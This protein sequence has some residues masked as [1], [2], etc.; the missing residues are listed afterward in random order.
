MV[1]D[2]FSVILDQF[3]VILGQFSVILG[4]FSVILESVLSLRTAIVLMETKNCEAVPCTVRQKVA[5]R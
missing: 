1:L 2:Q 5:W 3:S 4:R